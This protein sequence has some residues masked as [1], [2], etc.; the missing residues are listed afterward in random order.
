MAFPK[1]TAFLDNVSLCHHAHLPQQ[2]K[3]YFSC[4][5]AVSER[6]RRGH[7]E[8]RGGSVQS[9]VEISPERSLG[10]RSSLIPEPRK[11]QKQF[12]KTM[13]LV[14][15]RNFLDFSDFLFLVFRGSSSGVPKLFWGCSFEIFRGFGFLG[16]VEG[17]G[18]LTSGAHATPRHVL[19]IPPPQGEGV[20][21]L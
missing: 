11:R 14:D 18:D 1:K 3:F 6:G 16:S 19:P 17:R 21:L 15:F 5:L 12:Q 2:R 4:R 13:K 8:E 10:T 9:G 7:P 20:R